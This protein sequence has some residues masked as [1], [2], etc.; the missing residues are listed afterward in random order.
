MSHLEYKEFRRRHIPHYQP[1]NGIIAI[2][3]RLAFSLPQW[4]LDKLREEKI[5]A[6]NTIRSLV[7]K[8]KIDFKKKSL[9]NYFEYFDMLLAKNNSSKDWLRN[10]AI[11][12]IV[13]KA[14]AFFDNEKYIL[15]SFC[16]MPNHVHLLLKPLQKDDSYH[17]LPEI[18][19]SIKSYTAN[20][21]NR[22][23]KRKGKFWQT[24]YYDHSIRNDNDFVYQLFYLLNNPVKAGFVKN[25]KEW[26]FT[27]VK[28]GIL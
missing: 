22:I 2:S 26:K 10:E 19:H 1:E 20:I 5:S 14:I 18:T 24:E 12:E 27:Y 7:G 6:E 13:F 11:A 8:E 25:W 17:S 9:Q 21:G 3:F 15:Y 28:D 16:I 23:L 4:I